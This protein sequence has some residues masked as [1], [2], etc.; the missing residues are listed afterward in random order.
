VIDTI[1]RQLD[2]KAGRKMILGD[3]KDIAREYPHLKNKIDP[4]IKEVSNKIP[5]KKKC[6]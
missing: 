5:D 6:R 2:S 4:L 3:L 1:G